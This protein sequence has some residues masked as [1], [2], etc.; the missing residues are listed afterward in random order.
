MVCS[1]ARL[2]ASGLQN[3]VSS[4][5]IRALHELSHSALLCWPENHQCVHADCLVQA[6]LCPQCKIPLCRSCMH[7]LQANTIGPEMITNDKWIR[8][9]DDFIYEVEVTCMENTITSSYWTSLTPFSLGTR[10]AKGQT[11][12][13]H[14]FHDAMYA[15][16]NRT[17]YK[18]H[19]FSAPM[20]WRSIFDQ[21]QALEKELRIIDLPVYGEL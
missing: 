19:L 14:K 9:I 15:S 20:D 10:N 13:R 2:Q 8:Y 17:A 21:L 4:E 12:K 1:F 7:Y 5:G 18:G 11:R 16:E 6:Y 3:P